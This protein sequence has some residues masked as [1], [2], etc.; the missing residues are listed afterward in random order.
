MV[1]EEVTL[2]TARLEEIKPFY[3]DTLG[4][5][6]VDESEHSFTIQA[7]HTRMVFMQ[8]ETNE[9]PFYHFAWMIPSN[10]FQEAKEWV[11]SRVPLSRQDGQDQTYSMNW[12]A[13][14]LYFEDPAGNILE[15]IAHHS[16]HNERQHAFSTAD[17]LK[18]CEVGI[19]C[20]DVLE[21]VNK[22][23]RMG[24]KRW[25]EISDTFA[26]MGDMNGLFIVV[27][28]ERVWFFSEQ[29]AQIHAL[30]VVVQDIGKL[31]M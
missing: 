11:V 15:F 13:H 5:T 17:I 12:N 24:I 27:K 16:A 20:E 29:R 25:G 7:G 23:E 22:L 1:F 4:M 6:I 30:E 3:K 8:N 9:E 26:P 28:K 21:K 31:Q 2:Y 19:V 14:S 10:L 18:V